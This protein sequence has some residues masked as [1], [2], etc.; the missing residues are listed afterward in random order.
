MTPL[1][2][3]HRKIRNRGK[4]ALQY[5]LFFLLIAIGI[6]GFVMLKNLRKEPEK[7]VK[8]NL[9]PLVQVEVVKKD[10]LQMIV[11]GFGT[12]QAKTKVQLIPQVSGEVIEIHLNL[13]DGGFF[14]KD[15]PLIKIDPRD[16]ELALEQ[17]QADLAKAQVK[18]DKEQAEAD[19]AKAEWQQLN[20]G[21]PPTSSLVLRE[22]Q[23]REAETELQAAKAKLEIAKLNLERTVVTLPYDGRVISKTVDVGQYV[24]AGQAIAEIYGTEVVE[25]P[26]PLEDENLAFFDIPNEEN[27][28]VET[29]AIVTTNYAGK[30]QQWTGKVVRTQAQID[31]MSRMVHTIIQ[32][33]NPFKT[34]RGQTP[35]IPGMFVDVSIQGNQHD[36]IIII[37][38]FAIH[39]GNQ[40]W[41]A[42]ENKL[43]IK[44]VEILRQT[45]KRAYIT[46]GLENKDY[47][48]TSSI[49][50]VTDGMKIRVSLPE[51]LEPTKI[52]TVQM[53]SAQETNKE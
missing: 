47:L 30:L 15:E 8:K 46:A 44:Q 45:Q 23:I 29:K 9:G 20:P 19:V 50:T 40:V 2:K 51:N 35:L 7:Q 41:V 28:D 11:N 53:S 34:K 10:N 42:K 16:F 33:E 38:N 1:V 14:K 49:D 21:V 5:I 13:V 17:S 31:Q 26:V 12:V 48:I 24:N 3:Y 39:N 43:K 37:P 4:V 36:D 22:P 32:V 25:I 52:D 6:G 27:P 18:L